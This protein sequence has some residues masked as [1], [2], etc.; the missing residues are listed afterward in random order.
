MNFHEKHEYV[1]MTLIKHYFK[2]SF[3]SYLTKEI[4][5]LDTAESFNSTF[6][7]IFFYAF[8]IQGMTLTP[9]FESQGPVGPR[10]DTCMTNYIG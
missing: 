9:V 4:C 1:A 2:A 10:W 3:P 8:V 6:V 7:L 5:F